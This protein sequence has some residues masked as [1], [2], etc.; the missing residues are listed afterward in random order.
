M[1]SPLSQSDFST[2]ILGFH[3]LFNFIKTRKLL[4]LLLAICL[5]SDESNH[6]NEVE[7]RLHVSLAKDHC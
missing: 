1:V 5:D 4:L 6:G 2:F 3:V 7:Q